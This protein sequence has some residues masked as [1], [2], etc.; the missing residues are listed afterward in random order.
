MSSISKVFAG[1]LAKVLNSIIFTSQSAFL[2]GRHL[3]DGPMIVNEVN[4]LAKRRN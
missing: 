4:H 2:K 3:V 1:R